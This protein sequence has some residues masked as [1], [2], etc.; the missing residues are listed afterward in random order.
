MP[1]LQSIAWLRTHARN[2]ARRNRSRSSNN[3]LAAQR[4]H[5]QFAGAEAYAPRVEYVHSIGVDCSETSRDATWVTDEQARRHYSRLGWEVARIRKDGNCLFRAL[6]D[7]LYG[8]ERRHLELRRRLVDFI[9]LERAFFEPFVAGEGAIEY[10]ARLREAGA[11]GGHPE[12]VAASRLLGIHIVV[13]TGPMRRLRI[14]S[15]QFASS[16]EEKGKTIHLLLK[17]DHYSSLR[18]RRT[19]PVSLH[20]CSELCLCK[21]VVAPGRASVGS[22]ASIGSR[23]SLGARPSASSGADKR[24]RSPVAA[25]TRK[26]EHQAVNAQSEKKDADVNS[27]VHK[28]QQKAPARSPPTKPKGPAPAPPVRSKAAAPAPLAKPKTPAPPPPMKQKAPMPAS[29]VKRKSPVPASPVKRKAPVPASPVR[30]KSPVPASPVK[31]KAAPI[32]LFEPDTSKLIAAPKAPLVVLFEP[33]AASKPVVAKSKPVVTKP[34]PVVTKPVEPVVAME[35]EDPVAVSGGHEELPECG[36]HLPRRAVFSGGRRRSSG[37]AITLMQEVSA[38]LSASRSSVAAKPKAPRMRSVEIKNEKPPGR[39]V[40]NGDLQQQQGLDDE[41]VSRLLSSDTTLGIIA[42]L[43]LAAVSEKPATFDDGDDS[44]AP[45]IDPAGRTRRK[46][47]SDPLGVL[48]VAQGASGVSTP[49]KKPPGVQPTAFSVQAPRETIRRLQEQNKLLKQELSIEARAARELLGQEKRARVDQLR[50]TLAAFERKLAKAQRQLLRAEDTTRR[51]TQELAALRLALQPALAHEAASKASDG[52]AS[53]P[54]KPSTG[55]AAAAA[56]SGRVR[57]AES[58]LELALVRK[59]EVDSANK[60]L[61][62]RVDA[63]RRDRAIFDGIYKKLERET[64]NSKARHEQA[65][66]DLA[67]ATQ[68][69]DALAREVAQ[70][71]DMAQHEQ[72]EY[73]RQFQELKRSIEHWRSETSGAVQPPLQSLR[74]SVA[75]ASSTS[76]LGLGSTPEQ[77]SA[78]DAASESHRKANHYGGTGALARVTALS[79]WKIGMDRALA[80]G[81]D[82]LVAKYDQAFAAIRESTGLPDAAALARELLARDAANFQRFKRVEELSREEVALQ[83]QEAALSAQIEAF[84]AREGI[85]SRASQK[86]QC[87]RVE[88]ALRDAQHAADQLDGDIEQRDAELARVK[89][90][91]LSVHNT[92]AHA[93]SGGGSVSSGSV[94]ALGR[95]ITDANVLEYLQ[96]IET[97]TTALLQADANG[98]ATER[99]P[100]KSRGGGGTHGHIHTQL[101][102]SGH[103]GMA[104]SPLPVGHG[105]PTLPSDPRQ[106]LHVHVPSFGGVDGVIELP[107]EMSSSKFDSL[108][109]GRNVTTRGLKQRG[110]GGVSLSKVQLQRRRVSTHKSLS[111]RQFAAAL[112]AA[113][114]VHALSSK[115]SLSYRRPSTDTSEP[116]GE[117]TDRGQQDEAMS[118]NGD[119]EE[120]ER[121]LTYDELK[122]FA[123]KNTRRKRR[124]A[125]SPTQRTQH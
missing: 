112:A 67:R 35:V 95:G 18:E 83:A 30:R 59:N 84:K 21:R 28:K 114:A 6:S 49:G 86:Q 43:T 26:E 52:D 100:P 17:H 81:P 93:A 48:G 9:D 92:L 14:E 80:S 39:R 106:K 24:A 58:R 8:H 66:G 64:S 40:M 78:S 74:T 115:A 109:A 122:Q 44:E 119:E 68:A 37:A 103:G 98:D 54:G 76:S 5:R 88:A 123:A 32:V 42:G 27:P 107:A 33:E 116:Q 23:A 111:Q 117:A 85:A 104:P 71:Q 79:S 110:S 124:S 45:A 99:S 97:Y 72:I 120:D 47:S 53:T 96:A 91:V 63:A 55:V 12:L 3:R 75:A 41:A 82:G 70:L 121:A 60:H 77:P 101:Q 38:S 7:Q 89:A 4:A 108:G 15:D 2:H 1:M 118:S 20:G 113:A 102:T 19:I 22:R 125:R 34:K 29:P 16:K 56:A 87:R 61:L 31:R 25:E 65:Q 90:S 51:K 73:E 13:H 36:V 11:W 62:A 105:P 50:L 10:C 57:V 69:R 46:S 94:S